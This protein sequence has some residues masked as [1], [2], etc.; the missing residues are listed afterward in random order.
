MEI[1]FMYKK[2]D[3]RNSK[4]KEKRMKKISRS[5]FSLMIIACMMIANFNIGI[6]KVHA[7]ETADNAF[8]YPVT[9]DAYIEAKVQIQIMIM[10]KLPVRMVR[11]MLGKVTSLLVP[12]MRQQMKSSV[13]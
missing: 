10:K 6:V 5:I 3:D 13:Q 2:T 4:E 8:E 1:R 9:Q 7:D 11:N 12:N